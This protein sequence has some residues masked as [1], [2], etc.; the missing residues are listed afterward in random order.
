MEDPVDPSAPERLTRAVL[1]GQ[2]ER[3]ALL[4]ALDDANAPAEM[5][6]IVVQVLRDHVA[7]LR[8]RQRRLPDLEEVA[9]T[10]ARRGARRQA[11][12][13]SPRSSARSCIRFWSFSKARTSIW[14]MRS[15]LTL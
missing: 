4:S 11:V 14:R 2:T 10:G 12:S 7:D 1:G 3:I 9:G 6:E 13:A 15:R 5:R 8:G